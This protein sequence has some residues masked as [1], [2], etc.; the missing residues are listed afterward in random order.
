MRDLCELWADVYYP[1]EIRCYARVDDVP[2][3]SIPTRQR[4]F[5]ELAW[6]NFE[7]STQTWRFETG[8]LD[9]LRASGLMFADATIET[10]ARCQRRYI[11]GSERIQEH[12]RRYANQRIGETRFVEL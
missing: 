6:K 2:L 8:H 9:S 7:I 1:A 10:V 5:L 3:R 11:E 12:M 4:R